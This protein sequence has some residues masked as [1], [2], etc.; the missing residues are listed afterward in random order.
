MLITL[1]SPLP[2]KTEKDRIA[3]TALAVCMINHRLKEGSFCLDLA[4]GLIY[5]KMT[6]S[7][8][9]TKINDMLFEYMLSA[10]ADTIDEYYPKIKKISQLV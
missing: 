4:E 6:N 7:F 10:A 9:E 3:D 2:L 1:Y 8:Y 5:F